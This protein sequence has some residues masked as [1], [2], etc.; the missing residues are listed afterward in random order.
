MTNE[1]YNNRFQVQSIEDS[2]QRYK[3]VKKVKLVSD[4]V[5]ITMDVHVNLIDLKNDAILNLVM[6]KGEIDEDKIPEEYTYLV[7]GKIYETKIH[8]NMYEYIGSFGGMQFV[9][10]CDSAIQDLDDRS[11][12]T[13][14]IQAY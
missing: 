11:D 4:T 12:I 13:L 9:M 6:Y 10:N 1:V 8:T 5:T 2:D 7:C 14:G 3:V